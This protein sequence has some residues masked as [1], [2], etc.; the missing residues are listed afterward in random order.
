MSS[1]TPQPKSWLMVRTRSNLETRSSRSMIFLYGF[2]A[3]TLLTKMR[4]LPALAGGHDAAGE[5]AGAFVRR[6]AHC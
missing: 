1:P 3:A 6:F 5:H 2:G 4:N